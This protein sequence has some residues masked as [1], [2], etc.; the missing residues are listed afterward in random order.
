METIAGLIDE[1]VTNLKDEAV[2]T[3]VRR[4]VNGLMDSRPLFKY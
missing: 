3:S 2:I 4:K 1:V